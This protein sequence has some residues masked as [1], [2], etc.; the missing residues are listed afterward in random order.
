MKIRRTWGEAYEFACHSRACAP[1]PIGTG[2]SSGLTAGRSI[3]AQADLAS[4]VIETAGGRPLV[5]GGWVRDQL[6]GLDS[7]DV[8]IEVHGGVSPDKIEAALAEH[9]RVDAVGKAFGVLKF[10]V[11]PDQVDVSFPRR[12]SKVGSGHAGF[13]VEVDHTMSLEDALRRRDFTIN[14]IAYDPKSGEILDPFGGVADMEG[15]VLRATDS[16]TFADDPLRV[17]RGV[18]FASRFGFSMHP[19]TAELA[20][21][22]VDEFDTLAV[23]RVWTE[24]NKIMTK[25]KSFEAA[26]TVLGQTGWDRHFPEFGAVQG[27]QADAALAG[28]KLSSERRGPVAMGAAFRGDPDAAASF[29]KRIDAPIALRHATSKLARTAQQH[30]T[31]SADPAVVARQVARA[32]GRDATMREWTL[33]HT[34]P[35]V[36]RSARSQ[37]ILDAPK[38]PVLTGESLKA[39]GWE[40]GPR[41][42]QVLRAA[43]AQQDIEGWTTEAEALRWLQGQQ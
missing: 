34:D 28:T 3:S 35:A 33:V 26:A 27:R 40:P 17:L 38:P 18:Q 30:G 12:D 31:T 43:Q 4:T 19:E 32:L 29:L 13:Q 5:V 23:E 15:K 22:L 24:W 42:G 7:K 6:L 8:D 9:G 41:F 20:R 14:S 21:T 10:G 11:E 2:G 37:G 16:E 25:G 39:L 36:A 1:P